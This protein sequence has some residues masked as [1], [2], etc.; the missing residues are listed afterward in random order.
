M[1]PRWLLLLPILAIALW[2]PLD[3]YWQSDDFLALHYARD[4]DNVLRD[5]VGPQYGAADIWLFYRPLITLSFWLDQLVAGADPFVSHLSN[6]LAHG[7][8]A[9]LVAL[10]W[11]RFLPDGRAFLAGLLWAVIPGHAGS[12]S[13]AVGRVDSHTTVWCLLAVWLFLRQCERARGGAG[14]P[15]R[16]WPAALATLLALMS[17]ESAFVLPALATVLAFCVRGGTAGQRVAFA[18]RQSAPLWLLFC[19]CLGFRWL[20]LGGFGGYLGAS[21]DPVTMLSGLLVYVRNLVLP[22]WWAAGEIG[23]HWLA[24]AAI[25]LL[26]GAIRACIRPLESLAAAAL[27]C[28]AAAPLAAFLAGADNVHNLRYLYLPSVVIAGLLA[29]PGWLT[30]LLVLAA[31]AL[32]FVEVRQDHRQADRES[33]ALHRAIQREADDG[34]PSPMFVAGLPHVNASGT[35]VQLHFGVD[36]M[37]QPPFGAGRT[38]LFALRPLVPGPGVFRPWP[39][40]EPFALP[41]GSTWQFADSS[42]FGRARPPPP[43]PELKIAG[44]EHGV[45]D[46]GSDRLLALAENRLEIGLTTH[47]GKPGFFRL[48]VFTANG[49]LCCGFADHGPPGA[50][51]G[52]IDVRKMLAQG[53][54]LQQALYGLSPAYNLAEGIQVPTIIDL[55]P[56]FPALLEQGTRE[57]VIFHPTHRARRLLKFRFDRSYPAWVRLVQGRG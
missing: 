26:P 30:A 24:A 19:A 13:W 6:V 40:G 37:L 47:N 4:L 43:L 50:D 18:A 44:D 15:A 46:L 8:S 23:W 17:K 56:E 7:A 29:A 52:T 42:A 34:A 49:Y 35:A 16:A 39:A 10:I 51:H 12:I 1:T 57:G 2:W 9:L 25:P 27:F 31:W 21:Y 55:E 38:E 20:A 32:P 36:R 11:R 3:P 28:V 5:F 53:P 41:R 14:E 54:G 45:V 22:L 48:T 33:A